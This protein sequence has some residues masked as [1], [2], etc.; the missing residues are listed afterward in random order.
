MERGR[1]TQ[2]VEQQ[3]RMQKQAAIAQ[4]LRVNAE[5][6]ALADALRKTPPPGALNFDS[7]T[8]DLAPQQISHN[9]KQ[10]AQNPTNKISQNPKPMARKTAFIETQAP[11]A[12]PA[13]ILTNRAVNEPQAE[14]IPF[15]VRHE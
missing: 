6:R 13:T 2:A 7:V 14:V 10:L 9:P 11:K 8:S 4:A 3:T 5:G 15:P 1:L 12:K